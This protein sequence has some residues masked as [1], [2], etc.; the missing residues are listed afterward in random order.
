MGGNWTIDWIQ[1]GTERPQ[2]IALCSAARISTPELSSGDYWTGIRFEQLR[3]TGP[4]ELPEGYLPRHVVAINVGDAIPCS[5]SWL[6]EPP[7][8]ERFFAA[9]NVSLF[10][11]MQPY[12]AHW[13]SCDNHQ[14][15]LVEIAPEFVAEVSA[16]GT[17]A[18][19]QLE[20]RPAFNE[21]DPFITQLALALRDD[22]RTGHPNG[23]LYGE[24]LGTALT[25]H[26]LRKHGAREQSVR[27]YRNGL[28]N[29]QLRHVVQYIDDN[30]E[31]S[32]SLRDLAK[33]VGIS[34]YHFVRLF[35]QSTGLS[36]H[37]YVL[38]KR[39]GRA[40]SLLQNRRVPIAEIALRSGFGSQSSFTRAFQRLT[41][42]TPGI[43]RD[44]VSDDIL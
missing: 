5:V 24:T 13:A 37:Q 6:G 11:A 26:L 3:A 28:R 18:G 33:V 36:P 44:R 31:K 25:A 19:N 35:K 40:K 17:S 15:I 42:F 27:H 38:K 23:C 7:P 34:V 30:L 2:P 32:M 10:P 29:Y 12:L 39:I 4:G 21:E 16:E 9:G 8:T 22:L 20:L 14:T 41:Y 1:S 43:Y